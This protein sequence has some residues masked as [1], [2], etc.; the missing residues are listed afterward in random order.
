MALVLEL[1]LQI[2]AGQGRVLDGHVVG[3]RNVA[4]L[5]HEV[6]GV[7]DEV[8]PRVLFKEAADVGGDH[9]AA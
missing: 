6:L 9:G 7:G 4:R 1:D 8:V 3:T 2:V 5:V